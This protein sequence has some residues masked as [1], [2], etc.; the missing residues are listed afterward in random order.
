MTNKTMMQY[1]EWYLPDNHLHWQKCESQVKDIADAGINM[2]WL[3][4]AYKGA[5][6]GSSVGYDVYDMYDLGEF[7]QKGSVATKYG[8]R[9]EYLKCVHSY[10]EN[11]IEVLPDIVLNHRNNNKI[12]ALTTLVELKK[13]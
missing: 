9:D 1:F 7:D 2:V 3:P 13:S 10:Q 11:G 4:P 8:T 5:S 12:I 6:G